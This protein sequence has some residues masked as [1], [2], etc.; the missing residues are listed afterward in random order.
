MH[1]KGE[2]SMAV[3]R[4]GCKNASVGSLCIIFCIYQCK[5]IYSTEMVL[6]LGVITSDFDIYRKSNRVLCFHYS[7]M[8]IANDMTTYTSSTVLSLWC[9]DK[10]VHGGDNRRG[11][12][13]PGQQINICCNHQYLAFGFMLLHLGDAASIGLRH[14]IGSLR[15]QVTSLVTKRL[16]R[17]KA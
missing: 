5:C 4:F 11:Y 16:E 9:R 6:H 8:C 13:L 2:N 1:P 10:K 7:Y 14:M 12:G 17:V 3:C 15:R